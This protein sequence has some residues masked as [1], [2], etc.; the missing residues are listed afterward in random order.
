MKYT[1]TLWKVK[2]DAPEMWGPITAQPGSHVDVVNNRIV[3]LG[4][5][6]RGDTVF[7]ISE[8]VAFSGWYPHQSSLHIVT[9]LMGWVNSAYFMRESIWLQRIA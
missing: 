8:P 5:L 2:D 4:E 7:V 6:K 9:P 1:G 3:K